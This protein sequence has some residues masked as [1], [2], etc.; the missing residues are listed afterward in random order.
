MADN[1]INCPVI[2]LQQI[3]ANMGIVEYINNNNPNY[4]RKAFNF[5]LLFSHVLTC[6][7]YTTPHYSQLQAEP[8]PPFCSLILLKKKCKRY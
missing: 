2:S 1:Q 8:V 4:K 5:I 7:M 6:V 3:Q